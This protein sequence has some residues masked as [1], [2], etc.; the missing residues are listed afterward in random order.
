MPTTGVNAALAAAWLAFMAGLIA[1]REIVDTG[2]FVLAGIIGAGLVGVGFAAAWR[3]RTLLPRDHAQRLQLALWALAVGV[4]LGV[5]NLAANWIIAQ[6][7][8]AIRDLLVERM[9]GLNP[10]EAVIAAPLVEEV[11]VRLF[12]LSVMAW[13]VFR[14][15][16]HAGAAFG[17]ALVGSA[18]CFAALHLGRPF[19]GDP[20]LA[21][22][23]RLT[24][25]VKYTLAGVPLGWVFWRWGLPY[26]ILCHMAANAAHLALQWRVF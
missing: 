1:G 25:L 10:R 26:S 6:G 19:P 8:P 3:C 16:K 5:A 14:V 18:V 11:L 12:L 13:V 4:V 23:Y 17:T 9:R 15:T 22:Y 20:A 2:S 24:L 7:S 21:N